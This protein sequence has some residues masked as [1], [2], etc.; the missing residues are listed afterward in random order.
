MYIP[1]VEDLTPE[2]VPADAP[3]VLVPL[4]AQPVV[5]EDLGVEIVRLVRGVVDVVLGPLVEEEAVVV[6]L[7]LPAVQSPEDGDVDA[8]LVVH[9]LERNVLGSRRR[10]GGGQSEYIYI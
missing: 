9:E 7:L 5:A 4:L 3:A 8:V 2:N 6:D 10:K 1:V